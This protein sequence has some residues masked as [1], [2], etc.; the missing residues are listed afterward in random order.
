MRALVAAALTAYGALFTGGV[1]LLVAG[2]AAAIAA[3]CVGAV[4]GFA[5]GVFVA[6]AGERTSREDARDD[7]IDRQV[8]DFGHE[9]ARWDVTRAAAE[10]NRPQREG[11]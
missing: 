8:D 1:T 5:A 3:A 6:A 11:D 4:A 2:R 7:W 9:I 10:G